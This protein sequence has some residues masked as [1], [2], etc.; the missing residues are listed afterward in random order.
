MTCQGAWPTI[1]QMPSRTRDTT[2]GLT[3]ARS[4]NI[5]DTAL[6]KTKGKRS[7]YDSKGPLK[8]PNF[9]DGLYDDAL[10]MTSRDDA[11]CPRSR[12]YKAPAEECVFST[13]V[14]L[15]RFGAT[16]QLDNQAKRSPLSTYIF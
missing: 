8:I 14:N 2:A 12:Q 6:T 4:A 16:L 5:A 10:V 7:E 15:L 11:G 3:F 1:T 13:G 9:E